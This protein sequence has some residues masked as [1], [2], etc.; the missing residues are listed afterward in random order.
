MREVL[1]MN[2]KTVHS[3][4]DATGIYLGPVVLDESD[5]S[6][7]EEGVWL[8]PGNCM[9]EAPPAFDPAAFNCFAREGAWVLEPVP[10][11]IDEPENP[12]TLEQRITLLQA[13]VDDHLNTAARARRYDSIHTAALRAGYPGPFHDEGMAF[14]VWMDAVNAKCYAVLA[15][16]M[17]GEIAEPNE[18]QLLAMLPALT[19]PEPKGG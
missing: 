17:A 11:V 8:I 9:E 5:M 14:A 2:T 7:E 18:Q 19:L 15:Q 1:T 13:A 3:F 4:D 10:P 6:P 16:F 12:P